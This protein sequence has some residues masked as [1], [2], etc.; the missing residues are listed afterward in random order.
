MS[1]RTFFGDFKARTRFGDEDEEDTETVSFGDFKA[2]TRFGDN[3]MTM[4]DSY[5]FGLGLGPYPMNQTS[6]KPYL[7]FGCG[8]ETT[9]FGKR[10]G[11][12][13]RHTHQF[14][15]SEIPAA[16]RYGSSHR[17]THQ[18]GKSEIPAALRYGSETETVSFGMPDALKN[19]YPHSTSR[20][21]KNDIPDALKYGCNENF[22][23]SKSTRFGCNEN[24]SAKP[25]SHFGKKFH[26]EEL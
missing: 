13:H 15:K 3:S 17:H 19:A 26:F 1:K 18:F 20:F 7:G 9:Q 4:S 22:G 25:R 5:S 10:Y 11:S 23:K 2:R 24:F 14:G 21:G 6:S 12:S 16:L 8:D